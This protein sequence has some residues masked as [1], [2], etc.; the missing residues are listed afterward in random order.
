LTRHFIK[1]A[2]T[3][4]TLALEDVLDWEYLPGAVPDQ[5]SPNNLTKAISGAN[6]MIEHYNSTL[7]V[8]TESYPASS[9]FVVRLSLGAV[10]MLRRHVHDLEKILVLAEEAKTFYKGE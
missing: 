1:H 10:A 4:P 7:D 5:P 3:H 2:L 6:A 9:P 8:K